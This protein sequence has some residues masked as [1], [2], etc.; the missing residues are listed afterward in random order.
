MTENDLKTK[1]Q[2]IIRTHHNLIIRF[3]ALIDVI[4]MTIPF[5]AAWFRAYADQMYKPFY[6]KGNFYMVL[7]FIPVYYVFGRM[8]DAFQMAYHEKT[9]LFYAQTLSCFFADLFM[10]VVIVF[11][12]RRMPPVWPMLA[13]FAAQLV[14]AYIWLSIA[15]RWYYSAHGKQRSII[16]WGSKSGLKYTMDTRLMNRYFHVTDQFSY[17]DIK[18]KLEDVLSGTDVQ[19][20]FLL[21]MHSHER[22]L[23]L[24]YCFAHGIRAMVIPSIGDLIMSGAD[25]IHMF[26]LPVLQVKEY[27]AKIEYVLVKRLFDIVLSAAALIVLSPLLLITALIIKLT[28]GG[29]V[30]YRQ[31]RLTKDRREFAILKFRSMRMDAEKDGV[32]RLSTGADDDRITP[33]GRFIRKYRIDELPQLIN[34]LKGDM[35]IVGPRPE[36]PEIAAL[37][38][39]ELPEFALRLRAK[40]GLTGF[41]QVYGKYN[42]SPYYKLL[43]DL[44]YIAKPSIFMD[45]RIIFATVRVLFSPES[46]EGVASGQTTALVNLEEFRKGEEEE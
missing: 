4:L 2:S 44:M 23:V 32:A 21:D 17:H 26:N 41:A 27:Y 46:T 14:L 38:E 35:S 15:V 1:Q 33:I 20:L 34:I 29:T 39:K 7:L 19:T 36:R 6:F 43:L 16:I 22:N 37:Y 18:D 10:F 13:V 11:L 31:V 40:A 45:L 28:D 24:K 5:G 12:Y 3:S 42:T 8:Y 25:Q 30:F 9:D